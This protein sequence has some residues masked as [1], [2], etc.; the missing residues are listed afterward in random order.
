MLV[1]AKNLLDKARDPS[2]RCY[3]AQDDIVDVTFYFER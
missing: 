3:G 2:P 1:E